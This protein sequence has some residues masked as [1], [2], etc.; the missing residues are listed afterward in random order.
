MLAKRD[1]LKL[2]EI[3]RGLGKWILLGKKINR[4]LLN[5]RTARERAKSDVRLSVILTSVS[6]RFAS[7]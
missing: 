3:K 5:G 6:R 2:A 7:S 1:Q 4:S